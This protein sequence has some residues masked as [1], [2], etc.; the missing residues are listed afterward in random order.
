MCSCV[1]LY[2]TL[3]NKDLEKQYGFVQR[4]REH[5]WPKRILEWQPF[6]NEEEKVNTR[7]ELC[8]KNSNGR[9]TSEFENIQ[10]GTKINR[11]GVNN[12]TYTEDTVIL[13]HFPGGLQKLLEVGNEYGQEL[14]TTKTTY[15]AINIRSNPAQTG[16]RV[17]RICYYYTV[18]LEK[19][20]HFTYLG[21]LLTNDLDYSREIC[22]RIKGA[23]SLF[24]SV[25]SVFSNH[26]STFD[27]SMRWK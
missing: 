15:T 17:S 6:R 11:I 13:A 24:L 19:V 21:C 2:Y 26:A 5:T 12:I 3:R 23:G 10:H 9:Q 27:D 4:T 1:G 16:T 20:N 25:R 22:H 18:Q 8:I 7:M 14:N